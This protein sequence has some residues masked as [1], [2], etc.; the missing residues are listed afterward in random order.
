MWE[1]FSAAVN[2]Y[3]AACSFP[4]CGMANWILRTDFEREYRS[5]GLC[6]WVCPKGH[7]NCVLPSQEDI[8]EVNRNL[9]SHP[10]YYTDRCGSDALA[11]RRFRLCP[12]CVQE[13]L[14][15]FAVHEDGCKQWPGT[16]AAHRHCFCW[17]CTRKWNVECSHATVCQDPG[18]Q[19]VRRTTD[20][21]GSE[22]LE[23]G[24]VNAQAYIQ[25]IG[26]GLDCPDTL[27]AGGAGRIRGATRQGLLA[28]EALRPRGAAKVDAGGDKLIGTRTRRDVPESALEER[29]SC[30]TCTV[31]TI[32]W[33]RSA[34]LVK[35]ADVNTGCYAKCMSPVGAA[36]CKMFACAALQQLEEAAEPAALRGKDK[37]AVGVFLAQ[38]SQKHLTSCISAAVMAISLMCLA[39]A[40]KTT[41]LQGPASPTSPRRLAGPSSPTLAKGRTP[42]TPK[43]PARRTPAFFPDQEASSTRVNK[44]QSTVRFADEELSPSD[45]QEPSSPDAGSAETSE[46][47]FNIFAWG[48]N[49]TL[50]GSFP[51]ILGNLFPSLAAAPNP[52]DAAN[53]PTDTMATAAARGEAFLVRM[54]RKHDSAP[55]LLGRQ[56]PAKPASME[57]RILGRRMII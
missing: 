45:S 29:R 18:I 19:Q 53:Q 20:G 33:R 14:L 2:R 47:V 31:G 27:F 15:T 54:A 35:F 30:F 39:Q 13:G 49:F 12:E 5:R 51:V 56:A 24:F 48:V 8:N 37:K 17:H 6:N 28:M 46:R 11:L 34:L 57:E 42:K 50:P 1:N 9:L 26:T 43:T 23:I 3:S 21:E 7:R 25:W 52:N 41:I 10:E 38:A 55:V 22:K 16:M 4:G 40:S 44:R 32:G 36:L